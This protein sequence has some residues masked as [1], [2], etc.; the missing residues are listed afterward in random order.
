M[1]LMGVA[2]HNRV[3][4]YSPAEMKRTNFN[5]ASHLQDAHCVYIMLCV[6]HVWCVRV[7]SMLRVCVVCM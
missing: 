3:Q 1:T 4:H 6:Q 5:Q 2:V 7:C